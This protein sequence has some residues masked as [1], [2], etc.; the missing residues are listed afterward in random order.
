MKPVDLICALSG[1]SLVAAEMNIYAYLDRT[2]LA[3]ALQT[4]P[5]C[6][7]ALYVPK[8][9]SLLEISSNYSRNQ[10]VTCDSNTAVAALVAEEIYWTADNLTALC[11]ENCRQSLS[12]WLELVD[13]VCGV[14]PIVDEGIIKMAS[15]IPLAYR[16]GFDL[17]CLRSE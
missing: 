2:A 1:L 6:I 7:E 3:I 5:E 13:A 11:T 16:E 12:S 15:S 8:I 9:R 10:T 14:D 4:N 17:V